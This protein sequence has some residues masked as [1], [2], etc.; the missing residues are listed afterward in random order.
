MRQILPPPGEDH[1]ETVILLPDWP[2]D[3]VHKA[4]QY[5]YKGVVWSTDTTD[6]TVLSSISS[7]L[8]CLGIPMTESDVVM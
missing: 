2:L 7:L 4:V 1:E 3:I 6:H 8:E 5:I